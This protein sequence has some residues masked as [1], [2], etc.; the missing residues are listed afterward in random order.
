MHTLKAME[1][2]A[3]LR[4]AATIRPIP[5]S[6]VEKISKDITKLHSDGDILLDEAYH[7]L[8][9][10]E[11]ADAWPL[12]VDAAKKIGYLQG[13][14]SMLHDQKMLQNQNAEHF[15][16]YLAA[17]GSKGGKAKADKA[18]NLRNLVVSRMLEATPASGWTSR[19][20]LE[21]C[22]FS[23]ADSLGML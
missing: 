6:D 10:G 9:S 15:N 13:K 14:L 7:E 12:L 22:Y 21:E 8:L 16:E 17:N 2:I 1:M 19:E 23:I 3:R 5:I 4:H 18:S 11:A 20:K